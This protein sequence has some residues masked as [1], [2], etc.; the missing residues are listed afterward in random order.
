MGLS[1]SISRATGL[2]AKTS[3]KILYEVFFHAQIFGGFIIYP[4][5]CTQK[6]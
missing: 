6:E 1:H 3:E 2:I 4:Y 5:L